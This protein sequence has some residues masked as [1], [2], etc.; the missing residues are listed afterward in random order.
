MRNFMQILFSPHDMSLKY[1][2]MVVFK[3]FCACCRNLPSTLWMICLPMII[4]RYCKHSPNVRHFGIFSY[5]QNFRIYGNLE[6]LENAWK[7]TLGYPQNVPK[8]DKN[9]FKPE[10]FI[11]FKLEHGVS[12]VVFHL[13]GLLNNYISTIKILNSFTYIS[14]ISSNLQRE[15]WHPLVVQ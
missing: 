15:R 2:K 12:K 1:R 11:L 4:C 8:D 6:N 10:M 3:L 9:I 14:C 5:N 13:N 7:D